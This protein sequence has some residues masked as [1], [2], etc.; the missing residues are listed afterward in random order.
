MSA[1]R[2]SKSPPWSTKSTRG[3]SD[4][5]PTESPNILTSHTWSQAL[6]DLRFLRW[7]RRVLFLCSTVS[8]LS[9]RRPAHHDGG[10]AKEGRSLKDG[11]LSDGSAKPVAAST[12]QLLLGE[13]I[14][15]EID[16]ILHDG[17]LDS[18]L[19]LL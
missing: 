1:V 9:L 19:E 12:L 15:S 16:W 18:V 2:L 11:L 8:P 10:D 6:S 5:A 13:L 7:S 4:L 14:S 17:L 3:G